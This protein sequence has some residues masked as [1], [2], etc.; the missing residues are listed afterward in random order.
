MI[1]RRGAGGLAL[2]LSFPLQLM[3][4]IGLSLYASVFEYHRLTCTA[5]IHG[6][7]A[8]PCGFMQLMSESLDMLWLGNLFLLGL[9]TLLF[10]LPIWLV[11]LFFIR[12]ARR[13][14]PTT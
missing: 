11:L 7:R 6:P 5:S 10:A 9:P 3:Y 12:R 4:L 2:L 8:L 14:V 13:K 1:S